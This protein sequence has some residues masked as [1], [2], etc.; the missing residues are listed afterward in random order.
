MKTKSLIGKKF[1][2]IGRTTVFVVV[3][4][5]MVGGF[6]HAITG[7][8]LDGKYQTQPRASD[9]DFLEEVTL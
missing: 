2:L 7:E 1:R 3:H 6:I 8:T 4:E 9:V 5:T